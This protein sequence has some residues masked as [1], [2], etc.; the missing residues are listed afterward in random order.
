MNKKS[1]WTK[2]KAFVD[3]EKEVTAVDTAGDRYFKRLILQVTNDAVSYRK[4]R[5]KPSGLP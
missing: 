1:A 2:A 3:E 5:R 4:I